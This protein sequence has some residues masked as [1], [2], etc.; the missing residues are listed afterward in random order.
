MADLDPGRV[1]ERRALSPL[2]TM[3]VKMPLP[4]EY[5]EEGA[6]AKTLAA[7]AA[8]VRS[9]GRIM[10]SQILCLNGETGLKVVNGSQSRTQ[11]R[12]KPQPSAALASH[13]NPRHW[14]PGNGFL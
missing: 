7:P 13:H 10:L 3:G 5:T 2:D 11:Q 9:F 8:A 1:W 4:S 14:A 12:A 6:A